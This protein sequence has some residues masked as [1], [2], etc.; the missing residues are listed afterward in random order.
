MRGL[1]APDYPWGATPE[2]AEAVLTIVGSEWG[3]GS[4]FLAMTYLPEG[5]GGLADWFTAYQRAGITAQGAVAARK[6][7]YETDVRPLL[8]LVRQPTL[9][10]QRRNDPYGTDLMEYIAGQMPNARTE[11]IPGTLHVPFF[12]D[13]T[14]I[15]DAVDRFLAEPVAPA[16]VPS[17]DGLTRREREVAVLVA[18]GKTNRQ[19]A[20]SLSIGERTVH[21]H[22]SNLLGKLNLATRAQIAAWARDNG[23]RDGDGVNGDA[24]QRIR[25][26]R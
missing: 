5:D 14:P 16:I 1:T 20:D 18:C 17:V 13:S 22:V 12:E 24:N 19:I 10:L 23:L 25:L 3:M 7:W 8:P 4:R 2:R 26:V 15:I 6:A 21:T 9:L 11:L